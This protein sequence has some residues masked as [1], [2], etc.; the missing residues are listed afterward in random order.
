[1]NVRNPLLFCV[2]SIIL[3]VLSASHLMAVQGEEAQ[4]PAPESSAPERA[5]IA[6]GKQF[7]G[8]FSQ[9][10]TPSSPVISAWNSSARPDECITLTGIRFSLRQG[11]DEGSDTLVWVSEGQAIEQAQILRVRPDRLTIIIPPNLSY[12][13]Y[14]VWVQNSSGISS[15]VP[16]NKTDIRWIGP[17]GATAHR[18]EVK[19][20][21]GRDISLDNVAANSQ[22]YLRLKGTSSYIPIDAMSGNRYAVEFRLPDTLVL[23]QYDVFVHN[24]HGGRYGWAGPLTLD[25]DAPW[26]RGNSI[27]RLTPCGADDAPAIQAALQKLAEQENGG[28]VRLSAGSYRIESPI[29]LPSATRLEGPGKDQTTLEIRLKNPSRAGVMIQGNH[30]ELSGM[31]LKLVKT[32]ETVK[33]TYDIVGSD[34]PSIKWRDV[35]FSDLR[36]TANDPD[37]SDWPNG[38]SANFLGFEMLDC[39]LDRTLSLSSSDQWIHDN[40]FHGSPFPSDEAAIGLLNVHRLVL[41][42]NYIETDNWGSWSN[43][44]AKGRLIARR[45]FH[46][47]LHTENITDVFV[48]FNTGKNIAAP[49]GENKG[50]MMLL[51]GDLASWYG[52]VLSSEGKTVTVR[53]DGLIQEHQITPTNYGA[54]TYSGPLTDPMT[55]AAPYQRSVAGTMYLEIVGG[56]GFGQIRRIVSLT[57]NTITV[58]SPWRVAPDAS[59]TATLGYIYRDVVIYRNTFDAFP[60]GVNGLP[61]SSNLAQLD[62]NC[63]ENVIDGNVARRTAHGVTVNAS[64]LTQS[65]WNEVVENRFSDI[66]NA[67]LSLVLEDNSATVSLIGPATFGNVFRHNSVDIVGPQIVYRWPDWA[68]QMGSLGG[69]WQGKTISAPYPYHQGNV[70]EENTMSGG[71][72]GILAGDWDDTVFRRNSVKVDPQSPNSQQAQPL[73]FRSNSSALL[74]QNNY[75]GSAP[76][77]FRDRSVDSVVTTLV[78]LL[79][80]VLIHCTT[81]SCAPAFIPLLAAGKDDLLWSASA[82]VPW[83]R[84]SPV[85]GNSTAEHT[86]LLQ[87][88]IDPAKTKAENSLGEVSIRYNQGSV[89][90]GVRLAR[91]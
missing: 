18:G 26:P 70:M 53:T 46:A 40:H 34:R 38:V 17:L 51:H 84:I 83:I 72:R 67:G 25:V 42:R 77:Y 5:P 48:A 32:Q 78:P 2:L 21:F 28:T 47:A 62:G 33:P 24:G 37:A 74:V 75:N 58:D 9:F 31:T 85:Q 66:Q 22:V 59:S 89:N 13:M 55:Q 49:P 63:W 60:P 50:E 54:R 15:P 73:L 35:R 52:Q 12:T 45:F 19:R 71:R 61:S 79:A 44:E 27:A 3:L 11:A 88:E 82:N 36:I 16:I 69:S 29:F 8:T 4:L 43:P 86:S 56:T 39:E 68:Y 90:V 14:L 7:G 20:V 41:E 1:M 80:S 57:S 64:P 65:F 87:I 6:P 10:A 76:V 30:V 81:A 91:N 23:G